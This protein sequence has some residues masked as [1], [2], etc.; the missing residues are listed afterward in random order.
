MKHKY[1]PDEYPKRREEQRQIVKKRLATFMDLYQKGY[2]NDVV[3]DSENQRTLTRFL[4]AGR[5]KSNERIFIVPSIYLVVIK[6]EGGT[7]QD[8]RVLD[9]VTSS[10]N[11]TNENDDGENEGSKQPPIERSESST[12][13]NANNS[14]KSSESKVSEIVED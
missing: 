9:V 8:L 5:M 6:L 10:S 12:S 1:H 2:L 11:T 13:L 4:D 14:K 7:D 3:V